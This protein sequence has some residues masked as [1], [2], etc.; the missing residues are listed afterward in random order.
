MSEKKFRILDANG[1]ELASGMSLNMAIVFIKGYAREF[2][3]Y[4]I[5]L[6]VEELEPIFAILWLFME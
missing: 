5:L 1:I 2:F 4:H 6:T 3:N